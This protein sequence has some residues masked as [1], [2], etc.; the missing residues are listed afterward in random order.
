MGRTKWTVATSRFRCW[1]ATLAAV[2]LTLADGAVSVPLNDDF[3]V[4]HL[5]GTLRANVAGCAATGIMS[6]VL[7]CDHNMRLILR[8]VSVIASFSLCPGEAQI[9]KILRRGFAAAQVSDPIRPRD[10]VLS[11]YG[12]VY[13]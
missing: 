3:V 13:R 12:C 1:T 6:T 2:P 11:C 5:E 9:R 4:T 10:P 7:L 8:R